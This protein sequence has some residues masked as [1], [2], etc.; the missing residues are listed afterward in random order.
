[1]DVGING[2]NVVIPQHRDIGVL[3][4]FS[5]QP[6]LKG[7]EPGKLIQILF[8]ANFLP[9]GAVGADHANRTVAIGEGGG[10]DALLRVFKARNIARDINAGLAR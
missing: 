6:G 3:L 1:M 7:L 8:A 5:G 2:G 4:F 10:Q 9:V